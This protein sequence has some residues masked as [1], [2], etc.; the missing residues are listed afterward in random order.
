MQQT[1]FLNFWVDIL[2]D[3]FLTK[4]VVSG[5]KNKSIL[6]YSP[7]LRI[8]FFIYA[9]RALS[10]KIN[11]LLFLYFSFQEL[12][13]LYKLFFVIDLVFSHILMYKSSFLLLGYP[14]I[15]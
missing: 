3:M 13:I 1:A 2:L 15:K 4:D 5:F 7:D 8:K 14:M 11:P 12:I 6:T 10:F 9:L